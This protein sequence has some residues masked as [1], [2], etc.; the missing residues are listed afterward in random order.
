MRTPPESGPV[1]QWA[2]ESLFQ[3]EVDNKVLTERIVVLEKLIK[4]LLEK[5]GT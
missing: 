4:E 5:S 1:A 3:L 2:Y